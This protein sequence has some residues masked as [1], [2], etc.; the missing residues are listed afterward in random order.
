MTDEE[1]LEQLRKHYHGLT[2][3]QGLV[4][5][6]VRLYDRKFLPSEIAAMAENL[7][8]ESESEYGRLMRRTVAL[9][10]YR[11]VPLLGRRADGAERGSGR[12]F[13]AVRYAA[14][15]A[16][17]GVKPGKRSAGWSLQTADEPTCATC[18]RRLEFD[19]LR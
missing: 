12:R 2:P 10:D 9:A 11:F 5:L 18:R 14:D 17:C 8:P 13:H 3:E 4:T 15:E 1:Q 19:P 6:A 7:K 16:I